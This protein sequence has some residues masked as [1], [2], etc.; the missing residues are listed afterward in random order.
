MVSWIG[1]SFHCR[2]A[3]TRRSSQIAK[4]LLLLPLVSS[5][6]QI[7]SIFQWSNVELQIQVEPTSTP[8]TYSVSGRANLPENTQISV[9]AIRY[10]EP[11]DRTKSL[12]A[13]P[14]YSI[15]AYQPAD[16]TQGHWQ[17]NL[18]LWQ[19]D[20]DGNYQETWQIEQDKLGLSLAPDETVLFLATLTPIDD[21]SA[22][23]A[24]LAKRGIRFPQGSILSTAEGFRYAQVQAALTVDLPTG[25]TTPNPEDDNFGWGDRYL[26]PQE[27]QNPTN[28]EFPAERLTDAPPRQEELLR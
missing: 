8:G 5:C 11:D 27:P 18:N 10:L 26:I 23:E 22:L 4:L 25:E 1:S 14:T 28:L 12:N 7:Q 21:L 13:N 19:V 16:I 17:T 20:A 9:A 2:F 6:A 24:E 3:L 15:L